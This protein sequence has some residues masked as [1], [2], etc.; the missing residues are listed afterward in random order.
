MALSTPAVL[1]AS[2][3]AWFA[4][5]GMSV[6]VADT[7][8]YPVAATF[9]AH[10]LQD[11]IM[12]DFVGA[13]SVTVRFLLVLQTLSLVG[14]AKGRLTGPSSQGYTLRGKHVVVT[15]GS[16][17][18]GLCTARHCL[19][20]GAKVT[21]VVRFVVNF[22]HCPCPP[23]HPWHWCF[24]LLALRV[25]RTPFHNRTDGQPGA[26]C[27]SASHARPANSLRRATS[28]PAKGPREL[29]K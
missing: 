5:Y 4:V 25:L 1:L 23:S 16:E 6:W 12:Q 24:L 15:G 29:F 11:T 14:I 22:S 13:L 28:S 3:V 9:F 2:A 8:A 10:H 26:L 27:A 17:G 20:Q 19:A 18:L 21:L 7:F